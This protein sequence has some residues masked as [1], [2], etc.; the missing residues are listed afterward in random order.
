[1]QGSVSAQA[2][3]LR[4]FLRHVVKHRINGEQ[5][6]LRLRANGDAIAVFAPDAPRG[7][8]RRRITIGG[9]TAEEHRPRRGPVNGVILY[10]HGGGFV[11]GS[12]RTHRGIS[13]RLARG[14]AARV[15]TLNYRLAP[16]HPYP[17]ALD[18][19]VAV[20]RA[21]LDDGTEPAR[22]AVS[23][24]SAGGNLAF[25]LLLRLKGEGAPLPAAIV[26]LSP[27]VDMTGSGASMERN[28]ALDPFLDAVRLPD[29]VGAYA[30]GLD[31]VDPL[32]SPLFG[33]LAGLPPCLI[34][35]GGDEIL[36]DDA[37]RMQAAL[38]AAGVHSEL[39][40]WP[41]MPHVWQA[42][43]GFLPEGKAALA[44]ICA[45]LR[46]ELG[47]AAERPDVAA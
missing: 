14:A 5:D 33:D 4:A 15:I 37:V 32:L 45:F 11:M 36:L 34:Q 10:L 13:G 43:A 1:M 12:A 6:L 20:Y 9:L 35:C 7:G 28:A 39:E 25:A 16:E 40:V 29:V 41:R 44:R 17:C 8:A 38:A 46:T 26:G 23:G 21:L 18:D 19:V 2:R 42:F 27:F 24:D 47:R 3:M 30:P 22:I 31:P